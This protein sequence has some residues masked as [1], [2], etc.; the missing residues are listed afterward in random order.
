VRKHVN[1]GGPHENFLYSRIVNARGLFVGRI[2]DMR[3][4][5]QGTRRVLNVLHLK[6]KSRIARIEQRGHRYS[7]RYQLM[8]EAPDASPPWPAERRI[9]RSRCRPAG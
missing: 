7:R 6:L 2:Q 3:L 1:E 5:A 8:Q 9:F 4:Q